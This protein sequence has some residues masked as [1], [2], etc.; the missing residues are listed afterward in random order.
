M[1]RFSESRVVFPVLAI[2]VIGGAA[3]ASDWPCFRGPDRLGVAPADNDTV[4]PEW[5]ETKNIVWKVEMRGHGASSPIVGGDNVYVTAYSGYGLVKTDPY[6]NM[7]K[8]VR[9]LVCVDR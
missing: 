4:P 6:S 5:S 2:L 3:F 1:T 9:H 8:L 7:P